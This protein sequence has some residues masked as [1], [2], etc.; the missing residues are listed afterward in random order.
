ID[1]RWDSFKPRD[2]ERIVSGFDLPADLSR[3]A[4]AVARQLGIRIIDDPKLEPAVAHSAARML[5][6]HGDP[7]TLAEL[8]VRRPTGK[9]PF[10]VATAALL[11]VDPAAA[12]DELVDAFRD[13][14]S[15]RNTIT[16]LLDETADPRWVDVAK[17]LPAVDALV[18]L[19]AIDDV[20]ELARRPELDE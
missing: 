20:L 14:G 16:N 3:A 17:Q 4:P 10:E 9:L 8:V 1:A 15:A 11:R 13:D 7:E 19:G 12:Y 18:Q 2:R 6:E 5:L